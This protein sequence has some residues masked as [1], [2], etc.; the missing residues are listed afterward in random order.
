MPPALIVSGALPLEVSVTCW[1]DAVFSVTLPKATL[2]ELNVSAGVAAISCSE[3]V[4]VAPPAVAVSVAVWVVLTAEAVAVN[5][6]LDAP[7]AIVTEA[8]TVTALLLLERLTVVA[9]VADDDSAT[10]HAS[11]ADPV[12]DE[13]LQEIPLSV[14]GA[15][16]VPLTAMFDGLFE[17]LLLMLTV[18]L[19]GPAVA[20]SKPIVNTADCPGFRVIGELIP[21]SEN[22]GPLAVAPLRMS[23]AVPE[24]V[25]VTVFV[26]ELFSTS[27]PNATLVE[28]RLSAGVA[29]FNCSEQV[30]ELLFAVAVSVAVCV[31]LTADAVAVNPALDAPDPTVTEA[32]TVTAELLL[33]RL[34]VNAL[35]VAADSVTVQASV[36]DPVTDALL[37]ER[38]LTVAAGALGPADALASL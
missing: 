6:A 18:P 27:F 5:E 35:E 3:Y 7:D 32:G 10:A 24:S 30:A 23:C 14:D 26:V 37:Q 9:L 19:A 38:A 28:L 20:G 31:V 22:P 13:L 8:G 16:P 33:V 12:S 1:F 17:A 21:D 4:A 15:C 29:A 11:V 34:T 36:A 25:I 2:V